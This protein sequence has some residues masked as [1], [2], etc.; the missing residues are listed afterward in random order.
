MVKA[1]KSVKCITWKGKIRLK[2]P[3]EHTD[4]RNG[5]NLKV[6]PHV[7]GTY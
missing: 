3:H 1:E 5:I 6:E 2:F 4:S 7:C